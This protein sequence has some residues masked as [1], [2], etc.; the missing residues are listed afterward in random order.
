[1]AGGLFAIERDYF[2][3]I[4]LYDPGL[5]IWGGENFELSYK[6]Y[7]RLRVVLL[8][9]PLFAIVPSDCFAVPRFYSVSVCYFGQLDVFHN[10]H[11]LH[12]LVTHTSPPV[13]GEKLGHW[14]ITYSLAFSVILCDIVR[15]FLPRL[16]CY[17]RYSDE[18]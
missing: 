4:G 13:I 11:D 5:E 10:I 17:S 14:E 2:F 9:D 1:M 15:D 12:I 8:S 18:I 3:E 7:D 6:V 16:I